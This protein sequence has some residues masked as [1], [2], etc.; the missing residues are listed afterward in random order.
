MNKLA[1]IFNILKKLIVKKE[2]EGFNRRM[3]LY[4]K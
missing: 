2:K 3:F 4:F 1:N